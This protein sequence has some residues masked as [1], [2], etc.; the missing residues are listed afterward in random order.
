METYVLQRRYQTELAAKV[1]GALDRIFEHIDG[2]SLHICEAVTRLECPKK[3]TK[4]HIKQICDAMMEHARE[5][6][7]TETLSFEVVPIAESVERN[8]Q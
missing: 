1:G 6:G 8:Y 4:A 7:D 2:N 5:E 3:L